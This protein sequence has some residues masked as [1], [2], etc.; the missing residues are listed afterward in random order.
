MGGPPLRAHAVCTERNRQWASVSNSTTFLE[1]RGFASNP[2]TGSVHGYLLIRGPEAGVCRTVNNFSLW[3]ET[4]SM[5]GTIPCLFRLIPIHN[6]TQVGTYSGEGV[7]LPMAIPV[8]GYL[9][10]TVSNQRPGARSNFRYL[11]DITSACI[12]AV[13]HRYIQVLF[14]KFRCSPQ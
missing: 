7:Q 4:R 12:I 13:L 6:A 8:C 11:I 14:R 9:L 10:E 3:V 1:N 2:K 5:A